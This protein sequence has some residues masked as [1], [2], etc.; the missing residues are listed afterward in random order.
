[1]KL[2]DYSEKMRLREEILKFE[3]ETPV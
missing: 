1:M 3:E 2:K